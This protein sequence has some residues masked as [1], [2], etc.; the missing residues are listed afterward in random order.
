MSRILTPQEVQQYKISKQTDMQTTQEQP[1][2]IPQKVGRFLE[3]NAPTIGAIAGGITGSVP[4]AML[5]AGA[6]YGVQ[7]SSRQLRSAPE[8]IQGDSVLNRVGQYNQ[9][10]KKEML[11]GG[12]AQK[13]GNVV[14]G[15]GSSLKN[16]LFSKLPKGLMQSAQSLAK[17]VARRGIEMGEDLAQQSLDKGTKGGVKYL[18][19]EG[20]A[21]IKTSG[22]KITSF[23]SQRVGEVQDLRSIVSEALKDRITEISKIDKNKALAMKKVGEEIVRNNKGVATPQ[24]LNKLKSLLDEE[25]AGTFG[26]AVDDI[27]EAKIAAQRLISDNIRRTLRNNYKEIAPYL[28]EQHYWYR[29]IDAMKGIQAG[30]VSTGV[31]PSTLLGA[32]SMLMRG[33]RGPELITPIATGMYKAGKNIP[34]VGKVIKPTITGGVKKLEDFIF[35]NNE[36]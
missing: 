19:D 36:Q 22:D 35:G 34:Q 7:E 6:G 11:M 32:F 21:A 3:G 10:L 33:V 16:L 17:P 9:N 8:R 14:G 1:V 12:V 27:K 29:I 24:E 5:G 20:K 26:K 31:I 23:L 2:S 4:G 18:I 25:V 15:V 13:V 28:D 30:R